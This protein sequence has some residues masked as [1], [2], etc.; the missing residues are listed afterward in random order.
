MND[1]STPKGAHESATT[2]LM[3]QPPTDI[4][5]EARRAESDLTFEDRHSAW[6]AGFDL[7]CAQRVEAAIEERAREL[8]MDQTRVMLGLAKRYAAAKGPAWEAMI[9]E[10]GESE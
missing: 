4:A 6:L 9:A 8:L 5:Q 7:G 2:G 10:C 3:V 1:V